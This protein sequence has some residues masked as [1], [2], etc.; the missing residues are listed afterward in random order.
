MLLDTIVHEIGAKVLTPYNIVKTDIRRVYA[1]D[2][3]SDILSEVSNDTL[4]VTSLN[5]QQLI[6]VSELM[7]IP[8]ICLIGNMV[9]DRNILAAFEGCGTVFISSPYGMYETCGRL[10][11]C[12]LDE[13]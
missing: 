10:Y 9:P 4:L 11:H 8:V 7:D 2:K 6:R 13:H 12:F 1:G 3:M 5:N